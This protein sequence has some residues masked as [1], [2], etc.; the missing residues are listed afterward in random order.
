MA[1]HGMQ[2]SEVRTEMAAAIE[3][4]DAALRLAP[5]AATILGAKGMFLLKSGGVAPAMDAFRAARGVREDAPR[6]LLVALG[7]Q[8]QDQAKGVLGRAMADMDQ[9]ISRDPDYAL[10]YVLKANL[11]L[12]QG[13]VDAA[14]TQLDKAQALDPK[15]P[16]ALQAR[17]LIF[18]SAQKTSQGIALLR[19]AVQIDPL[20][21]QA[22]FQL[23]RSLVMVEQ[24]E[25]AGK[26]A[27]QWLAMLPSAKRA[28]VSQMMVQFK[29]R[30]KK[31]KAQQ[32]PTA[33]GGDPFKLKM[34]GQG[35]T[36]APGTPGTSPF[37]GQD[38]QLQL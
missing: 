36:G 20:D 34:P 15:S 25:E 37:P 27:K 10:A 2:Q 16:E 31:Y 6:Y 23:W 24:E 17:A 5:R 33:P 30:F 12:S 18:L 35:G 3:T 1:L 38:K 11:L 7:Y 19:R 26:A 22:R 14:T 28:E 32:A 29:E 4:V 9:A 8:L 21:D 13:K